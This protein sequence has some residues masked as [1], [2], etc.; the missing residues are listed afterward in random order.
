MPGQPG[1]RQPPACHGAQ[2]QRHGQRGADK[3][4]AQEQGSCAGGACRRSCTKNSTSVAGM[5][6]A[7]PLSRNTT[8][9]RRNGALPPGVPQGGAG[10]GGLQRGAGR[11][12]CT[13][14]G[15]PAQQQGDSKHAQHHRQA[16]Q[17][18]HQRGQH[19]AHQRSA[20]APGHD[21]AALQLIAAQPRAPGLVGDAELAVR[22]LVSTSR[23]SAQAVRRGHALHGREKKR[24]KPERTA[25][26]PTPPRRP[27]QRGPSAGTGGRSSGRAAGR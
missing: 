17:R 9:R 10:H 4:A 27:A 16:Q 3:V 25:A 20:F 15:P 24:R 2:P 21:A 5:A 7:M 22:R 1:A 23:H 14:P 6:L 12:G 26:P 13:G 18:G 19:H 8:S 11:P